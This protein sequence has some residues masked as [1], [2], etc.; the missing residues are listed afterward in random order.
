MVAC[1]FLVIKNK[2]SS[3]LNL[4]WKVV[5]NTW[6]SASSA[7]KTSLLNLVTYILKDSPASCFTLD[8]CEVGC[9][10]LCPP[11]KWR[12]KAPPNS[13][14]LLIVKGGILLNQ[15]LVG[16]FKLVGNAL[17][18]ISSGV[19]CK[20]IRL[21]KDLMWS[22]GSFDP[23]NKSNWGSLNFCVSSRSS[24]AAV[25]GNAVYLIIPSRFLSPFPFTALFN[26]SIYFFMFWN[27]SSILL[28]SLVLSE[29]SLS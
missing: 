18:I 5:S 21:L 10:Y 19:F 6:S 2:K 8:K 26:L 24:I 4:A 23:S 20:F 15:T 28:G 3:D 12:T 22:S 16:P 14:K 9:L 7:C 11:M 13:S 17:H 27:S 29:L 25:N 1:G